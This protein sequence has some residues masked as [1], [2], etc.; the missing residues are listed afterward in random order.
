M[1]GSTI[2]LDP[3]WAP[4][5]QTIYSEIGKHDSENANDPA[6]NYYGYGC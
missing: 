3:E 4:V 5:H 2:E 1:G 6:I